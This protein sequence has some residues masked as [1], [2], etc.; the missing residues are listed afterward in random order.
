MESGTDV[1]KKGG[2]MSNYTK[3]YNLI[4][5]LGTEQ[6]DINEVTNIN[7]DIIDTELADCVRKDGK[8]G[9]ST[10]DFTDKYK[11]KLDNLK[12]NGGSGSGGA[13]GEDGATFIPTVSSEGVIS[14]TNNK[15]LDNPEPVNIKGK[16]GDTGP[17]GPAPIKGTDYFTEAEK[18]EMISAV[19]NNINIKT[20]KAHLDITED[21]EAG[22]IITIPVNYKVGAD[23]L[24]VFLNGEYLRKCTTYDNADTGTYSEVGTVNSIS[25]QIKITTAYSLESGDYFDFIVRGVYE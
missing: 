8:K 23:C 12:N 10:N 2:I 1:S 24:D 17:Q 11:T 6:Y 15:G 22:S 25:N 13:D 20:V 16:D 5:P 14:W 18:Q 7:A 4:K 3:N 19:L 9:L 21:I